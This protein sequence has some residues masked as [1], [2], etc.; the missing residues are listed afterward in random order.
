MLV[1]P[2]AEARRQWVE[3]G[4]TDAAPGMAV[5]TLIMPA[6][7]VL[8]ARVDEK[9][10]SSTDLTFARFE[11]LRLLAFTR[12]GELSLGKL[13][14]RLQVHP[15]SVTSAV[16]RLEAQGSVVPACVPLTN[17]VGPRARRRRRHTAR[18]L[19]TD[20]RTT[21]VGVE[22]DRPKGA[23]EWRAGWRCRSCRRSP[24]RGA[25]DGV[26]LRISFFESRTCSEWVRSGS[27]NSSRP[28][29]SRRYWRNCFD[30]SS[31]GI[32]GTQLRISL[33]RGGQVAG[34]EVR[35]RS[36]SV[37]IR[38]RL[39]PFGTEPGR[40]VKRSSTTV[41]RSSTQLPFSQSSTALSERGQGDPGHER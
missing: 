3:H 6:K 16:D 25:V 20:G 30:E 24:E 8:R 40:H 11:L 2:I 31:R 5:V 36:S 13:G 39:Q 38:Q 32:P 35:H 23:T 14:V 41:S 28:R 37:H 26:S 22:L 4:W 29:R 1:D 18:A 12:H 19:R 17:V 10:R 33:R 21:C 34:F 15:T 9:R 7:Q 27:R